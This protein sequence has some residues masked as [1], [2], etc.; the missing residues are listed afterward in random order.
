VDVPPAPVLVDPV[1][2]DEALTN[3]LDNALKFTE[4]A[5]TIRVAA[6]AADEV[7]R[8]VVEDDGAGVPDE[9]LARLFEKFYRAPTPGARGRP[10][11]GIGLAVARGLVEAMGGKVRARRSELGGLA[12]EL[13]LRSAQLPAELATVPR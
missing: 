5:S 3:L 9:A 2:L 13:E 1:F 4:G 7:V 12:V 6:T 8:L 10:G 11:T